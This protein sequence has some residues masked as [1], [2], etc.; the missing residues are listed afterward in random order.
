MQDGQG[1]EG[2]PHCAAAACPLLPRTPCS[3]V[4]HTHALHSP[5][6]ELDQQR[7]DYAGRPPPPYHADPLSEHRPGAGAGAGPATP[8]PTR[9]VVVVEVG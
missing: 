8:T 1:R 4:H 5:Q 3:A 6:A 9:R 7:K 2:V